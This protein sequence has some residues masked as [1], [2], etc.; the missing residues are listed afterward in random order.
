MILSKGNPCSML[1]MCVCNF[2]DSSISYK[3]IFCFI[4][5]SFE[6]WLFFFFFLMF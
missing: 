2:S 4:C 5:F 3:P 6:G 1:L